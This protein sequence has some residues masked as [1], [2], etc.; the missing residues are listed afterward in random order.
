[1][2]TRLLLLKCI[3]VLEGQGWSLYASVDQNNGTD[4]SSETDSWYCVKAKDWVPGSTVF[5]R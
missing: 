3:E 1:M 2:R 4:N 5:H